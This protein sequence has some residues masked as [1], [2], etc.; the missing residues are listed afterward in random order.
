MNFEE[1]LK[2]LKPYMHIHYQRFV[3]DP[4]VYGRIGLGGG[5]GPNGEDFGFIFCPYGD[6]RRLYN[7]AVT[8]KV[9]YDVPKAKPWY[10][11]LV[12]A[13]EMFAAYHVGPKYFVEKK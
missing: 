11:H 2:L 4:E 8:Q 7:I 9:I 13:A 12:E 6:P 3:G 5:L 1:A 10:P